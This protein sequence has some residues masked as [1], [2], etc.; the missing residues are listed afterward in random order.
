MFL[1]QWMK[2]CIHKFSIVS[3][4]SD[5]A[6]SVVLIVDLGSEIVAHAPNVPNVVLHHQRHI[7][8]H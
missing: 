8:R 7:G 1:L 2:F 4:H 5:V 3:Y 6:A